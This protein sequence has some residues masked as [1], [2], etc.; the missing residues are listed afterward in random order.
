MYTGQRSAIPG[1]REPATMRERLIPLILVFLFFASLPGFA[2]AHPNGTET[3]ITTRPTS[4]YGSAPAISGDT[5]VWE[6]VRDAGVNQ[7]YRYNLL[8]GEESPANASPNFQYQPAISGNTAVWTEPDFAGSDAK[9]V[10]YD[11][12]SFGRNEYPGFF[13]SFNFEFNFPKIYGN[14]LVWQDFNLT[15]GN[16]DISVVRNISVVG[17]SGSSVFYEPELIVYGDGDQKHPEIFQDSLVYENWTGMAEN[18]PSDIWLYNLS[19]DT[20]VPVSE[21]FYQETLPHIYGERIAWEASNL[22]GDGTHIHV[23]D[24]GALRRLTPMT[25]PPMSQFHPSMYGNSV[26]VEDTRRSAYADIYLYD[27][28][29]GTE[30]WVAPNNLSASQVNPDIYD[31]RIVWGD[32]RAGQSDQD[33]YLFTLGP[34]VV[35]PTADFSST[36]SAGP[37]GL[38][39][40]FTDTSLGSPILHRTWNFS[41]GSPWSLNPAGPVTHSFASAGVYP[42]KLTVG[43]MLCR[44]SSTDTCR[45]SIYVDAPP[46][47]GFSAAPLY[48]FAPLT[49]LF[50]DT[51]CGEVGTWSWDFG[52]GSNSTEQNPGHVYTQPGAT[53]TVSL[54][55]NS[56]LGN[57]LS[58]TSTQTEYIRTLI[59]GTEKSVTP[60]EGITTNQLQHTSS[61]MLNGSF[62]TSYAINPDRSLVTAVP[63]ALYGWQNI[64]FTASDGAGFTELPDQTVV[65]NFSS[66]YF[67]TG[68]LTA[69]NGTHRIGMNYQLQDSEYPARS[70]TTSEIWEGAL[71]EDE[72]EFGHFASQI[73][74]T[75]FT[76][77]SSI[78]FTAH[79][80]KDP[81]F[82]TGN[83]TIT[84]GISS[85][86]YDSLTVTDTTPVIIIGTGED[87]SGNT[88][89]TGLK[90]ARYR[91]GDTDYFVADTPVYLSRFGLAQV[92]GSGNPFQLITLTLA[93]IIGSPQ[94]DSSIDTSV[95]V[96]RPNTTA[97]S[98]TPA[99]PPG[100]PGKS[101]NMYSNNKGV[102]TQMTMLRS[103]DGLATVTITGG[104][105]A[106]DERGNPLSA[107]TI[108]AVPLDSLP[109]IP[110]GSDVTGAGLAY[111][112]QPDNST[113]SP[114]IS[115]NITVPQDAG[116]RSLW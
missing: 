46:D 22:T 103:T 40:S 27:L 52:D 116:K 82:G 89:G 9:I 23:S 6:D 84:L 57:G 101:A 72:A 102:I 69:A 13:D 76:S 44:N 81:H 4:T 106:K 17:N 90:P 86:W 2:S 30:T 94:S 7:I 45:H 113:F 67:H 108:T 19:N 65:G 115:F 1:R 21:Q 56:T 36:P 60:V 15:N 42:V 25:D 105:T 51:S 97:P 8:S 20:A 80:T 79:V 58:T 16:W 34:A 62:L 37:A 26:V 18:S 100:D 92:S 54:T 29:A 32:T 39:V 64:S 88:L 93:E 41:D 87:S 49:V 12:A 70:V 74:P 91:E 110:E 43:N 61:L 85:S 48:G 111:D 98:P 104:V 10:A 31:S 35:C 5:I 66:V 11:I 112:L 63:P 68:N 109:A 77:V 71:P 28:L 53:Y 59:G 75:G 3:P 83:A 33:V 99:T 96:V 50:T 78:P 114:S 95:T 24:Q 14:T 55:V 47:A 73:P 38:S 107:I